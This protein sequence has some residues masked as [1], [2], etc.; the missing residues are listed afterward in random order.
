VLISQQDHHFVY[1]RKLK[2]WG[3]SYG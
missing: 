3:R 2:I 1:G